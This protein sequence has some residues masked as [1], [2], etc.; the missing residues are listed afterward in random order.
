MA[1]NLTNKR[2]GQVQF[3]HVHVHPLLHLLRASENM[4]PHHRAASLRP[5]IPG[6][7]RMGTNGST[8]LEPIRQ[9]LPPLDPAAVSNAASCA[10]PPRYE[11]VREARRFTLGTLDPGTLATAS[12][13]CAWWS[14]NSSPTP[15][16]TRCRPA[17]PCLA[18][19][20][21]PVRLHLMRWTERLVCAVRDPSH[22]GP[23][24]RRRTTSRRS[25]AAACS[26][27]SPSATAGAGSR[28]PAPCTARSVWALFLLPPCPSGE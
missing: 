4:D 19:P 9:G 24:A 26:W 12:T 28:W 16:G 3:G 15:C 27:W 8:M 7:P 17:A 23:V 1:E 21:G 14:P 2:Y 5:R 18:D 22:D 25:R 13:T 6:V 11:A 20:Y 10:L